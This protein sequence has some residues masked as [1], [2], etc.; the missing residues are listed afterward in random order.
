M[1]YCTKA[2]TKSFYLKNQLYEQGLCLRCLNL[3]YLHVGSNI[4]GGFRLGSKPKLIAFAQKGCCV[5]T[6]T[7][8]EVST[9]LLWNSTANKE[10]I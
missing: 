5:R 10:R 8:V 3:Y 2:P 9:S 1:E 4:D 6:G 7:L